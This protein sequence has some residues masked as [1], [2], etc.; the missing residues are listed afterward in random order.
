MTDQIAQDKA[1][2]CS[3]CGD[4][5]VFSSGEQELY[6]LR[7]ITTEPQQCPNCARGRIPVSTRIERS[8]R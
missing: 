7:G 5:F 3:S 4:N 2:P 6:R 1:L 8:T